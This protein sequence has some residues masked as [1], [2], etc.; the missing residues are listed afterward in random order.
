M[1][2]VLIRVTLADG[3]RGF[4]EVP[5]S[6]AMPAETPA[7]IGD[8]LGEII[9]SLRGADAGEYEQIT[10]RLRR[11]FRGF[12]MTL[13]GLETALFRAYLASS[14]L[15]EHA[16][17]GGKALSLETDITIPIT[18]DPLRLRQWVEYT[19][20]KGFR[21]Y[22]VKMSG[23][24]DADKESLSRVTECLEEQGRPYILRLDGN[25]G[26]SAASY[27]AMVSFLEK[28]AFPVECFEQ[29]LPKADFRGFKEIRKERAVPVVLDESV[30]SSEDLKRGIGD[31]LC[32][33]VNIK[34]AKSGISESRRIYEMAKK[35][36]L[37]VMAGCM[38]ETM[39]GLSGGIYFAAGTGGVDFIDLDAIHFL[40]H[41]HRYGTVTV[42]SLWYHI[43]TETA[44]APPSQS[45]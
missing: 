34:V 5:T 26:Y 1:K 10:D 7:A 12:A 29:P 42:D 33:G 14:G 37:K 28:R 36:G 15:S 43:G 16:Y 6:H 24:V 9:P 30:I 3:S 11:R 38:I 8:L 32:D 35:C 20:R 17:W 44:Q 27:R 13:S 25:Q 21:I 2:S 4:G 22:K 40:Y 18:G 39:V 19:A 41:K 31:D 45:S 23:I